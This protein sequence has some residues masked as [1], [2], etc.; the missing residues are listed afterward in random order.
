ME[1]RIV[2]CPGCGV[3]LASE[4]E[5]LDDQFH[6]SAACRALSYEL[7]YYTLSLQDSDFIHQLV[8]DTYA[9]QHVGPQ[10]KPIT[11]AFALVGL[12]LVCEKQYTG[13]HVQHTHMVLATANHSK[14]W[15]QF[16]LP[17]TKAFL[18]VQ[19]VVHSPDK[20]KQ[21]MITN[22]CQSVWQIWKPEREKVM[23]LLNRY[24]SL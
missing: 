21:E 9:A 20:T 8:V 19:D 18:T 6:A 15:P 3:Q 17:T 11:I 16:S 1:K 7:S 4:N 12:Y 10:V 22:W 13:K 5:K 14:I 23:A 2:V 24:V